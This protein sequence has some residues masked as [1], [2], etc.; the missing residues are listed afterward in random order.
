MWRFLGYILA[1][2]MVSLIIS[3]SSR[4]E[5]NARKLYELANRY[6][7]K[8]EFDKAV[9]ILQRIRIDYENTEYAKRAEFEIPEYQELQQ[10]L[11]RNQTRSI[12]TGF[13]G[14]GRALENYKV[15]FLAYPLTPSDLDKLPVLVVPEWDDF[16][17]NPIFYKPLYSSENVPRHAPDGYVLASF[18]RDGLPGGTDE[19]KDHFYKNG[20]TVNQILEDEE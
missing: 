7:E 19:N 10:L 12:Q 6:H 13:S 11:I 8:R 15:R 18:G 20:K 1:I 5:D 9:E 3:C 2:G 4:A 14:I 16:W 17:G